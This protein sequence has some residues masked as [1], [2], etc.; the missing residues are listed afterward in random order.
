MIVLIA[1]VSGGL[2]NVLANTLLQNG[3]TVYGTVRDVDD[4]AADYNYSLLPMEITDQQSVQNAVDQVVKDEGR[5]DVVIN[6]VNRMFI[7]STEEET[8][9]E[10]AGLYDINVFGALRIFKAALPVMRNQG[11][12]TLISMSSLGGLLAVPYMGAYTSAK[13]ALEAL[14]EALYHEIREDG[15]E[16]VI[17]QPVAMNMER[18]ADSS[19]LHVVSNAAPDSFSHK[20]LKGMERDTAASKLTPE[21]VAEKICEII[22]SGKK[23]LRVPMDKAKPVGLLK[24][25]APQAL[26]NKVIDGLMAD[27]NKL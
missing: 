16:M 22:L 15:I 8:V 9:D 13:F 11:S 6:C 5:L 21:K 18:S 10:V 24:R 3:M 27:A 7:G 25:L 12:G 14:S 2:G 20:M 19:H 17:M 26:I 4:C 1:G 23:P